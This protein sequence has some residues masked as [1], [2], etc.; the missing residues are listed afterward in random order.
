MI[1]LL[2]SL[3]LLMA[4]VAVRFSD[5][6]GL[7]SLLFFIVMGMIT[8]ASGY[9]F[10]NYKI[11]EHFATVALM[12]IMFYGGFG[13]N[14][15]MAK[16]AF[17]ESA[18]L[19]SLG[20]ILTAGFCGVFFHY[21]FHLGWIEGMLLASVVAS[22]DYASVSSVLRSKNLNLKYQTAP[23]L[24]LESGSNDPTAYTM[25][26][27]F[28]TL[29]SKSSISIPL[30]IL[31]QVVF[32]VAIGFL[33]GYLI[34]QVINF[35]S[36]SQ[37]GLFT[38]FILAVVCLSFAISTLLGG[39]GYLTVYILG[40]YIG[41]HEFIG[42][43]DIVF[44][45]DGFTN[46]MQIGMFYLL[47]LLSDL[48]GLKGA[49]SMSVIAAI[50]LTVVARPLA[51]FLLVRPFRSNYAQLFILSLAGLRGAAAIAFAIV[52]VNSGAPV[53]ADIFHIV[54]GI[55]L[56]SQLIQGGLLPFFCRKLDMVDENDTVLKTFNY[57]QN[58]SDV[59]FITSA[60]SENSILVGKKIREMK[61]AF[62]FI[63]AKIIRD[64]KTII[65]RGE[66]V[67]MAGD[68]IVVGGESYFDPIGQDLVELKISSNHPWLGSKLNELNL[69]SNSLI[70]MIQSKEGKIVIP[71][72]EA[73][74]KEGDT[75]IMLKSR[76][77]AHH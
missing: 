21:V 72:G 55:C 14:W 75:V 10:D 60:V 5:K 54:F 63:I 77:V 76:D 50:F 29:L 20:V 51:V 56:L 13:T 7:P 23:I 41:N 2:V 58:K 22:T 74:V 49:M 31:T 66:T 48:S 12:I 28:I 44:F 61:L 52:V 68:T 40:I 53:T 36:F 1:L 15:K 11:V 35:F 37:D 65:P 9:Q 71:S 6:I 73:S 57:Y 4:L 39:N 32:G 30:L 45:F 17:K 34:K 64:N 3:V 70:V 43:R 8:T 27:I 33:A 16:P 47:G 18:L 38:V 46:I 69:E 42:K 26:I 19:A 24:E 25:T 59:G 62:D 67:I